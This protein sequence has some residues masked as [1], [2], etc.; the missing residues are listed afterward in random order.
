MEE[1]LKEALKEDM[2]MVQDVFLET[3]DLEVTPDDVLGVS[4]NLP[5]HIVFKGLE[6]GFYDTEVRDLLYVFLQENKDGFRLL[7]R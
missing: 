3:L 6:Y 1:R 5:E 4:G 2:A 7:L